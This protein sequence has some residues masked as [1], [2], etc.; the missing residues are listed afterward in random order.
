VRGL[1]QLRQAIL[2]TPALLDTD[3]HQAVDG[4]RPS[5]GRPHK[6]STQVFY[7]RAQK[8]GFGL[9]DRVQLG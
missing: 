1:Q 6:P 7:C 5:D 8:V 4:S 3:Q 9:H 2:A